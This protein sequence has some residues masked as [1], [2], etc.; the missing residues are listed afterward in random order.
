MYYGK[1]GPERVGCARPAYVYI[2]IYI[3]GSYNLH[4]ARFGPPQTKFLG[5]PVEVEEGKEGK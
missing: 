2:F 5:T 1:H 3:Y 4:A